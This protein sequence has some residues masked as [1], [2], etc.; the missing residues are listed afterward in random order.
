MLR[1]CEHVGFY[2]VATPVRRKCTMCMGDKVWVRVIRGSGCPFQMELKSTAGVACGGTM[3]R[4]LHLSSLA[5]TDHKCTLVTQ[6]TGETNIVHV[7][8][9]CMAI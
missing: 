6:G 2:G 4:S 9:R 3:T 5:S 7:P 1:A 8:G